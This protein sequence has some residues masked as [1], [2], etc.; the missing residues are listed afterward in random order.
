[1]SEFEVAKADLSE[2]RL[3]GAAPATLAEGEVRSSTPSH[4]PNAAQVRKGDRGLSPQGAVTYCGD[5]VLSQTRQG[6]PTMILADIGLG[7]LLWTTIL[8]FFFVVYL[9]ILFQIIVDIFRDH[10]LSGWLKAVWLIALLFFPLITMLIYLIARGGSMGERKMKEM[11]AAQ[12]Q[13]DQYIKSVAQTAGSPAEQI[14]K[15]KGLLDSGAIS[16]EEFDA[17]KA[18]ALS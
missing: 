5:T 15:A 7:E 4:S 12:T 18:K 10:D 8:I 13:Y 11:Q 6:A 3:V 2:H 16:Q 17:L 1:V 9:M 14:E